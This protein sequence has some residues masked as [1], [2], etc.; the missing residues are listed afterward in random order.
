VL[1]LASGLAACGRFDFDHVAPSTDG[2]LAPVTYVQSGQSSA[3][4]VSSATAV[5]ALPNPTIADDLVIITFTY[6]DTTREVATLT[7]DEGNT[8][9]RAIAPVTWASHPWHTEMWYAA[10]VAGGPLTATATFS[11][12]TISFFLAYVDEYAGATALDQT[13]AAVGLTGLAVDSGARMVTRD[14]ELIFGHGEGQGPAVN[15]D[16]AFSL[17]QGGGNCEEDRLGTAGEIAA[18]SFA[19]NF[20]GEWIA[21]MATFR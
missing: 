5:V 13:S 2:P 1:L 8:Y 6:D 17:R 15:C 7:D 11:G 14:G 18:A 9:A 20:S 21:T 10:H 3:L 4:S 16:P 19:L 12:P